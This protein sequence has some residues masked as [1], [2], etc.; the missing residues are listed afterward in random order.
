MKGTRGQIVHSVKGSD[1][2][3]TLPIGKA[4]RLSHEEDKVSST[5]LS[6]RFETRERSLQDQDRRDG[7]RVVSKVEEGV[8]SRDGEREKDPDDPD[9]EGES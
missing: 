3:R 6:F 9:A 4:T 7:R 2:A 8:Y 1:Q 5:P